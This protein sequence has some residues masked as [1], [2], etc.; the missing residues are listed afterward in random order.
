MRRLTIGSAFLLILGIALVSTPALARPDSASTVIEVFPGLNA[1]RSALQGAN[2]G[3]TLNIHAGTYNERVNVLVDNV[4]LQSAGDGEVVID[5]SC[6]P[7]T[8]LD[9]SANGV[10]LRGL[11]VIGAGGVVPM[12]INFGS[13][14]DRGRVLDTTV[15]DTCGDAE[16]GV[17]V[18]RGG[19]IQIIGV[20]ASGFSDA[21]IYVGAI[22]STPTGPLT[23]MGNESFD[24]V[25]GIIIENSEGGQIDVR[26]NSVHD[27]Q[28][29]GI[30]ITNSDGVRIRRNDV[31]DNGM[32]GIELDAFSDHNQ[33]RQNT[34]S[35][36]TY[37]LANDGGTGNCFINNSYTTSLGDISC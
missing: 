18:F 36:H 16:Y 14:A 1:I 27:N 5:A 8:T 35:G 28:I 37:D 29:T 24:N 32:S 12:E 3:D 23:V 20:T 31:V 25:R 10:T 7:G 21:G 2:P 17:N 4:T 34:T 13:Q 22:T 33:I 30:W 15:Q 26:G 6:T 11:T 9:V 19:S